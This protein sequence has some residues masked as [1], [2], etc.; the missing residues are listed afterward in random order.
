MNTKQIRSGIFAVV[1]QAATSATNAGAGLVIIL[2]SNKVDYATYAM[3]FSAILLVQG[4]QMALINSPYTT[5][6][7][8][9]SNRRYHLIQTAR[10]SLF[11]S[12]V[13]GLVGVAIYFVAVRVGDVLWSSEGLVAFVLAVI[14]VTQREAVRAIYYA[15]KQP[16]E[17]FNNNIL[18]CFLSILIVGVC[19]LFWEVSSTSL[20]LSLGI[21]GVL[22]CL[23]RLI[24]WGS[25]SSTTKCEVYSYFR[26]HLLGSG[27]WALKGAV[28]TW[29]NTNSYNYLAAFF[30]GALV[31]ADIAASRLYWMPLALLV[32]GWGSVFRPYISR[33]YVEQRF[34]KTK[35][36]ILISCLCALFVVVVYQFLV[37]IVH[38]EILNLGY[39]DDYAEVSRYL[40]FWGLF[41][42]LAFA[43]SA[44]G[45]ALMV[46]EEGYRILSNVAVAGLVVLL[47]SIP[48]VSGFA[49]VA[50][51]CVL[52]A[53]EVVQLAI[54]FAY[55]R[56]FL[57]NANQFNDAQGVLR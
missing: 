5:V 27:R 13:M 44:F 31:V 29:I 32:A 25:E 52:V 56:K 33:W 7:N 40:P 38:T 41:F 37:Q 14:G 2:L 17:A 9:S 28:T 4:I 39:A 47:V 11:F 23:P 20:L 36:L 3:L 30:Y 22:C 18:F 51:L 50:I 16:Q 54:C 57:G 8:Q 19:Y 10:L 53:I 45:A 48:V 1:D 24:K 21:A 43:R 15:D 26:S 42:L 55:S 6:V 12:F 49:P 46:D 35:R 34:L